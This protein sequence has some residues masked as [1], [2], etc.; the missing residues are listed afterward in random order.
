MVTSKGG[1]PRSRWRIILVEGR[2]VELGDEIDQE[3]DQVVFGESIVRRD[4]LLATLLGI[5][6]R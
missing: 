4:W 6:S 2:E 1:W 3:E 5:P